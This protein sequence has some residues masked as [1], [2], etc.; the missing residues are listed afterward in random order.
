MAVVFTSNL[1]VSGDMPDIIRQ[2]YATLA[3]MKSVVSNMMPS[4]YLAY[5]LETHRYY[6]Y[7]KT[8]YIKKSIII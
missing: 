8:N 2:Q 6:V 5:C 1:D 3:D 4:I 7:D